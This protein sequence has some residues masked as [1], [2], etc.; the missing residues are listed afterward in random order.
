M[1]NGVREGLFYRD[2]YMLLPESFTDTGAFWT[3]LRH[4]RMPWTVRAVRLY[5]DYNIRAGEYEK[6]V[7][8]APYFISDYL[9]EP[10][11]VVIESAEEV[12]PVL[13]ELLDQKSYNSR[14]RAAVTGFCPGC[15]GF[16]T[17]NEHDSSLSGHFDEISLNGFC[18]YRWE[19]REP[20]RFLYE[21]ISLVQLW[22]RYNYSGRDAESIL[23]DLKYYLKLSYATGEIT[24]ADGVRTLRLGVKKGNLFISAL[25]DL[26][27]GFVRIHA[28]KNYSIELND[29]APISRDAALALIEPGKIASTRKELKKYG[30]SLAVLEFDAD[31]E[32]LM[33]NSLASMEV[34][35]LAY[36][37]GKEPGRRY[38]LFTNP[39]LSLMELR[40]RTPLMDACNARATVYD[41]LKTARYTIS[42]EM[43]CEILDAAPQEP[44]K[45]KKTKSYARAEKGRVLTR[46]QAEHL[47]IYLDIRLTATGCDNTLHHT[48]LWLRDNLPADRFD[49]AIE[50]IQSQG[51]FCDCEVLMNAYE[52]YE[53]N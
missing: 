14:L 37:L 46:A 42:Y 4:A 26:L 44:P 47:F 45:P 10:E 13:V 53:L 18:P 52:D 49:A 19:G 51:G 23:D 29:P 34:S 11:T 28:D 8:I 43:P 20:R 2:Q 6:G 7:S 41:A 32:M 16:G 3:A 48:E 27:S 30:L 25:T 40:Y 24:D 9:G 36:L 22:P 39:G 21:L 31:K 50:E 12:F 17:L 38:Y 1:Q 15:G 5:E 35:G 33:L